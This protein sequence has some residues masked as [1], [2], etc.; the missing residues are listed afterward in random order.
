MTISTP[1]RIGFNGVYEI[2]YDCCLNRIR[3]RYLTA[4]HRPNRIT[5]AEQSGYEWSAYETRSTR[6]Q[7][8]FCFH[9]ALSRHTASRKLS[10]LIDPEPGL[11][12]WDNVPAEPDEA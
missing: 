9:V 6:N 3:K 12:L 7:Y 1:R 10:G 11:T 8:A 4:R 5:G 2:R